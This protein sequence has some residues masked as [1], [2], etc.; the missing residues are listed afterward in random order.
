MRDKILYKELEEKLQIFNDNHRSL[1]G[2]KNNKCRDVFIQQLIDSIRRVKYVFTIAAK[3]NSDLR[4]DPNS[5]LFDPIKAAIIFRNKNMLGEACWLTFLSIH[6]GKNLQTG[7]RL[8]R[9]IYGGLGSKNHW[10]WVRTSSDPTRFKQWLADNYEELKNGDIPRKFGNHRKY[11]SLNPEVENNT[12]VIIESYIN[13]IKPPRDQQMFIQDIEKEIGNDPRDVF[14]YLYDSMDEV[15]RFGR[16]AKFDYLTMLAK[17]GLASIE[18]KLVYLKDSTGPV[19]GA[20]LL[21]DGDS[22]ADISYDTLEK[23]L[24]ILENELPLGEIG[25]QVLEDALCNW[26]KSPDDYKYFGG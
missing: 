22:K 19:K 11:E 5:E 1:V 12:G 24:N 7:W 21:F 13:W 26:Q 20:K 8:V 9:D 23:L 14:T 2:I 18:P 6:F 25:M 4:A 15:I 17:L 3:N 10:T 16:T